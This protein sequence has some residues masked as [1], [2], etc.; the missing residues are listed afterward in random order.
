MTGKNEVGADNREGDRTCDVWL[1]IILKSN[2]SRTLKN[3]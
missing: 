1:K 3:V 2:G